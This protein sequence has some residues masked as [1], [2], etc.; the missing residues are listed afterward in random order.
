MNVKSIMLNEK[1]QAQK[2]INAWRYV[3]EFQVC[4]KA[5]Q[6]LEIWKGLTGDG[7]FI[8]WKGAC[9]SFYC[10]SYSG[11]YYRGICNSWNQ[12]IT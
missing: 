3:R 12:P 9:E 7:G 6:A 4:T 2:E 10:A 8:A 1:N 5:P 11:P